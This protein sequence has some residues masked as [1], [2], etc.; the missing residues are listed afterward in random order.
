MTGYQLRKFGN[1]SDTARAEVTLCQ[2]G[3][4]GWHVHTVYHKA[5]IGAPIKGVCGTC[6]HYD[7]AEAMFAHACELAE[8]WWKANVIRWP[9]PQ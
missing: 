3:V 8:V 5:D 4:N 9:Q 7:E 6:E 1:D 2:V